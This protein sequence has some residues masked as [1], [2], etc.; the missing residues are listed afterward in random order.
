MQLFRGEEGSSL[1]CSLL[2]AVIFLWLRVDLPRCDLF[3]SGFSVLVGEVPSVRCK[4][5][6]W[7]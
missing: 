1:H 5:P 3:W 2:A 4:E 7:V 6:V